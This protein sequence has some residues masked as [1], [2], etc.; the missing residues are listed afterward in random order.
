MTERFTQGSLRWISL[1]SPSKEEVATLLKELDLSP[2][3]TSDLTTPVPKNS[4]V[5]IDGAVK[6]TLDFPVVKRIDP[7]HPYEVKFIIVKN[8]LLTVHYEEMEG[9]DRFKRQFEVSAALRKKQK[10]ITSAHLFI[11]L[12]NNLYE[13]ADTKLDYIEAKLA[14]IEDQIFKDN[15]KQMVFEISNVSKKLIT[16]RH[17]LRGHE[18]VFRDL[19][20]L[21]EQLYQ[22]QFNTDIQNLQGQYFTMQ[23]RVSTQ[24]ETLSALRETNSA[25]L[26][27]KQN[28]VMK[29]LT[30]MAFV[31]FPLTLFSSMFGMNTEN[32]PIIGH[33]AD[34]WIIV[35]IMI[36]VAVS[37]FSFFKRKG[38][39]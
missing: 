30:I 17:I 13:S 35:A 32:T 12:I 9:I 3:L 27:T 23:R 19:R 21:F 39:M 15:E 4:A 11:S 10:G 2:L 5:C 8:L 26:T 7:A 16:F 38:W 6:V 18:E 33:H 37:F 28:E 29:I 1:K 22:L 34:F 36:T 24:Y 31:T 25:M 20:P 14:E